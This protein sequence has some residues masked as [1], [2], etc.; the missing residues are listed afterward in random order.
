MARMSE[1]IEIQCDNKEV[2]EEDDNDDYIANSYQIQIISSGMVENMS[3]MQRL[4]VRIVIY[5]LI[6]LS[7][8]IILEINI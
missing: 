3:Q 8:K 1:S 4:S 7:L 5:I 2:K 6:D